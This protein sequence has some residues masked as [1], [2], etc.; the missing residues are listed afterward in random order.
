[1]SN[2]RQTNFR[3]GSVPYLNAKPLIYGIED[4]VSLHAPSQLADQLRIDKF[5]AGLVPIAECLAHDSYAVLE[6]A[7]ISCR[8]PVYSVIIAHRGPLEKARKIFVDQASRTSIV[9]MQ[10]ILRERFGVVP[11]LCPLPSYD[12]QNPPDTLLLIGNPAI[13]FRATRSDYQ[14][15]DLGQAWWKL[16]KLPF[17]FAAWT[18]RPAAALPELTA[19][20][21]Q[22]RRNGQAHIEDIVKRETEFTEQFRREY[23]TRYIRFELGDE[24]KKGIAAFREFLQKS[25]D[26]RQ[27]YD[28]R[29]IH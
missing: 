28:L 20:L 11:E 29:Y 22:A 9:L 26:V 6:G 2:V 3:I 14:F 21:L 15:L 8:G 25:S 19:L 5:D 4:K 10:V 17:V 13:K 27:V 16:T 7:S 18:M 23:L 1:M 24:E 12:F